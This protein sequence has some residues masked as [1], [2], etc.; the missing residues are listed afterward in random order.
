MAYTAPEQRGMA[1]QTASLES[2]SLRAAPAGLCHI[3]V[4]KTHSTVSATSQHPEVRYAE[5]DAHAAPEVVGGVEASEGLSVG[6][7]GQQSSIATNAPGSVLGYEG[8]RSL[9]G[10]KQGFVQERCGSRGRTCLCRPWKW[11]RRKPYLFAA[12]AVFMLGIIALATLPLVL[13]R[14]SVDVAGSDRYEGGAMPDFAQMYTV[15]RN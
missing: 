10:P 2:K 11:V 9:D 7:P 6:V 13:H 4:G 8:E 12:T 15:C 3:D 1:G 5:F 14:I